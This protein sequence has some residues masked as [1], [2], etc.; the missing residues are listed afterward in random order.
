MLPALILALE[1]TAASW[2]TWP[3]LWRSPRPRAIPA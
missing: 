2:R 1:A 3:E